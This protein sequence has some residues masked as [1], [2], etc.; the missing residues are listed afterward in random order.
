MFALKLAQIC[1]GTGINIMMLMR[2]FCLFVLGCLGLAVG[3]GAWANLAEKAIDEV[4]STQAQ[5][6][7]SQSRINRLD[8]ETRKLL[9]RYRLVT[10]Q[11][12][13]IEAYNRQLSRLLESQ[14]QEI[15]SI[16][17]QI[18]EIDITQREITPL[19][20]KMVATLEHFIRLDVPF[21]P[22]ERQRRLANLR[23]T[24]D[25]ADVSVSEKFRQV[26]EAYQIENDYGRTIE[27]YRAELT[28]NQGIDVRTV[29]FLRIGRVSL[30]Y[31]TL[32]GSE[33]GVWDKASG[34]W[35][36]LDSRYRSAMNKGLRI[37]RKQAAPDL[38]VLPVEVTQGAAQ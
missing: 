13:T 33:M 10:R 37:A 36:I 15:K 27:A 4:V 18:E 30:F 22:Q 26:I 9:E 6:A 5:G 28:A 38:L 25:R 11:T 20:L 29:D 21:L 35:Q 8:D 12:E 19:M 31:Q 23:E 1:I 17:Q 14:L 2:V 24:L 34:Q 3:T 32:D 7:K 16:Q